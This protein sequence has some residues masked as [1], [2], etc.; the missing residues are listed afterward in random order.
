ML[1]W[2]ALVT[3]IATVAVAP[4]WL[5]AAVAV[6]VVAGALRRL[7]ADRWPMSTWVVT[8]ACVAATGAFAAGWIDGLVG[9]LVVLQGRQLALRSDRAAL[10]LSVLQ[11]AVV[12]LHPPSLGFPVALGVFGVVAGLALAR[13]SGAPWWTVAV[14]PVGGLVVALALPRG[15]ARATFEAPESASTGFRDDVQIGALAGLRDDPTVAFWIRAH[16]ADDGPVPGPI[17]LRGAVLEVFDGTRFLA[18]GGRAPAAPLDRPGSRDAVVELV[19]DVLPG[20][21][22]FTAGQ[23]RGIDLDAPL[24]QDRT[25]ALRLD[26]PPGPATYALLVGGG[27]GLGRVDGGPPSPDT[28][29]LP[30]DLDPGV[31]ALAARLV[32]DRVGADAVEAIV[33]HVSRRT[34]RRSVDSDEGIVGFLL[35][36][37]EGHCEWFAAGAVVLLRAAGVPSRVVT[38]FAY[39]APGVPLPT[40]WAPVRR[41]HAHAWVEVWYDGAWW[42]ID[43]TSDEPALR[44]YAPAQGGLARWFERAE[45]AF[46]AW[47][48]GYSAEEQLAGLAVLGQPIVG[49]ARGA[50]AAG[51]AALALAALGTVGVARVA[52]RRPV[53]A[54]PKGA[55]ARALADAHARFQRRGFVAPAGL[56]PVAAAVWL[57]EAGAPG[58][59]HL[60]ELAWLAYRVRFGGEPDAALAPRAHALVRLI[61]ARLARR[62]SD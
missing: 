25:G 5:P 12:G 19:A 6:L 54:A 4:R 44:A 11:L 23:V 2:A 13:G 36:E 47:A 15:H 41:A 8:A 7:G 20:G 45:G 46:R 9:A 38:G 60:E 28:Y 62:V 33:A 14:V 35:G 50:P 27:L 16:G 26:G 1:P 21:V 31:R 17:Y 57:A 53:R 61:R 56:P 52:A 40:D 3:S 37:G 43:A 48:I 32:G 29:A 34:Y 18:P 58:A 42:S 59:D 49:R 51:A 55:V 39:G 10:L 22:V 24:L 30:A